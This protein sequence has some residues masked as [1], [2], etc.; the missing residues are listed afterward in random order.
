MN[1]TTCAGEAMP[2]Y[3]AYE[4]VRRGLSGPWCHARRMFLRSDCARSVRVYSVQNDPGPCRA[5]G[6]PGVCRDNVTEWDMLPEEDQYGPD[7]EL[8]D[9]L[10]RPDRPALCGSV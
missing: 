6:L 5:W 9:W 2:P 3:A 4:A 8:L 10:H 7:G 1:E